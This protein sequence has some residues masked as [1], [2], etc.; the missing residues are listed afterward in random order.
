MQILLVYLLT[1][2]NLKFQS[3]YT[4][5]FYTRNLKISFKDFTLKVPYSSLI[6]QKRQ[7]NVNETKT[8]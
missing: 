1:L 6:P 8:S 3:I 2:F 7:N 5:Y 4:R